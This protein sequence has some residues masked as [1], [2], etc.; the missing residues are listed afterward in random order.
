MNEK[1]AGMPVFYE[2]FMYVKTTAGRLFRKPLH[3]TN[4]V[5]N[6]YD[7]VEI[8]PPS[9]LLSTPEPECKHDWASAMNEIMESGMY[10]IKC[11][12]LKPS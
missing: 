9:Q 11:G 2:G 3:T 6:N 1:I 4:L 8:D 7:W 10:C 5:A 12:A